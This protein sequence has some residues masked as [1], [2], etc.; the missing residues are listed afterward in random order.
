MTTYLGNGDSAWVPVVVGN[1]NRKMYGQ[2]LGKSRMDSIVQALSTIGVT[3]DAVPTDGSTNPVQSNGVFD[4]LAGKAASSHT[5]AFADITGT[6]NVALLNANNSYSGNATYGSSNTITIGEQTISRNNSTRLGL[7]GDLQLGASGVISVASGSIRVQGVA[8]VLLGV[9]TDRYVTINDVSGI[10]NWPSQ[11]R[12]YNRGDGVL[13][14]TNNANN[15]FTQVMLG[16]ETS[17]YP[18]I[19]RNSAAVQF[20][21]ADNSANANIIAANGQFTAL[22]A[23]FVKSDASGNLSSDNSTYL[24]TSTASSTY[25]AK[26]DTAAMLANYQRILAVTPRRVLVKNTQVNNTGSTSE[27]EIYR[28]TIKAA[29][30]PFGLNTSLDIKALFG[31]TSSLNVKTARIKINGTTIA[32]VVQDATGEATMK[33]WFWISNRNSLSSQITAGV[34]SGATQV[35]GGWSLAGQTAAP[36]TYSFNTANDLIITITSQLANSG[37]FQSLEQFEVIQNP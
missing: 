3:T 37:E 9:G 6:T 5:H 36:T 25:L 23:G 17:S 21:L 30:F 15:D 4:A 31:S 24:T 14:F 28:D 2:D 34:G 12:I 7:S 11:S 10:L 19:R 13:K 29:Q 32:T 27:V 35:H 33:F 26:A 1:S 18:S 20:R 16:G 8:D 22:T